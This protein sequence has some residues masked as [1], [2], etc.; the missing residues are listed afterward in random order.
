VL[1]I[2]AEL[3]ALAAPAEP[4]A[5]ES[6][7]AAPAPGAQRGRFG[8]QAAHSRRS[9]HQL[10]GLQQE[11]TQ[12][13]GETR[14]ILVTVDTQAVATVVADWTGIPTRAWFGT[15]SKP[16]STCRRLVGERVIGQRHA[17]ERIGRRTQPARAGLDNP[18]KPIGV[19]MLAGPSGVGKT[20]TALA[21][22]ERLYRGEQNVITIT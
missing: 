7:A 10:G 22:A 18:G 19:F 14:L 12:L 9:I 5:S 16:C 2:R 8:R 11:L 20:G 1:A 15:K 4:R 17:L 6:A 13:Q 21:L 3:R